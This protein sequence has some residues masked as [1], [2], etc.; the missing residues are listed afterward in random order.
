MHLVASLV[1]RG[2]AFV[3]LIP[4]SV[5]IVGFWSP[6]LL[7]PQVSAQTVN[8]VS[9][10]VSP[11]GGSVQPGSTVDITLTMQTDIALAGASVHLTFSGGAYDNFTSSNSN[12]LSFIYYHPAQG[13]IVFICNNN[14]CAPGTYTV[15]AITVK[16]GQTGTLS[17][18][19][20]PK[21]TVDTQLNLVGADGTTVSY[22]I[23]A[24][25]AASPKPKNRV[26]LP[27]RKIPATET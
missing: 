12:A 1:Q 24:S 19:F 13:D 3:R 17:V 15:A 27:Y 7:S 25:A 16:A 4:L 22:G 20:A 11:T 2:R 10:T 6:L 14:Y 26:P 8:P 18:V 5:A 9:Y 21:E 23:T